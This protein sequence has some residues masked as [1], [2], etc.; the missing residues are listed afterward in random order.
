MVIYVTLDMP[1]I[2]A[3]RRG[4]E[5]APK[6]DPVPETIQAIKAAGLRLKKRQGIMYRDHATLR[7][8]LAEEKNLA[9]LS[10]IAFIA[11]VRRA[12]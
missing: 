1:K 7:G 3:S 9:K 10:K 12:S 6:H 8:D 4:T 2:E 5:D 11:K